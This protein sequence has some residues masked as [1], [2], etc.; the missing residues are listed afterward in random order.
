MTVE[1]TVR[2]LDSLKA[3]FEQ[4]PEIAQEAATLAVNDTAKYARRLSSKEIRD[5]VNFPRNYLG[6]DD[7]GRLAIVKRAKGNDTEAVIRGRDRPTSLTRFVS[8]SRTPGRR[9]VTVRVGA[10]G[11]S[12]KMKRAFIL[13]LRAG[14]IL[15][16][17]TFNVGLAIRLRKGERVENKRLMV[18]FSAGDSGLYLLYGPSV[19]QV[20]REVAERVQPSVGDKLEDEFLRQFERLS[21]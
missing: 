2:G 19:G 21:K 13:G 14:K 8:G 4:L 11:G 17:E 10:N 12:K 5:Q 15:D 3:Y 7:G 18:Q 6:G 1:V 20:F 9:G 16:D